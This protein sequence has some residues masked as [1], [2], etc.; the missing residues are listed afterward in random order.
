MWERLLITL[1]NIFA[2]TSLT[3]EDI[4]NIIISLVLAILISFIISQI[5]KYTHY[6]MTYDQ[7]FMVSLVLL[8]PIVAAIML[9]VQGSLV[10]SL[11]LIG[12]L[13]IIRFR[14]PIKDSLDMVFLFWVSAAGLGCGTYNWTI[15]VIFSV[16]LGIVILIMQFTKYGKTSSQYFVL[17]INGKHDYPLEAVEE[18]LKKYT[19]DIRIRSHEVEDNVWEAIFEIRFTDLAGEESKQFIQELQALANVHKISLLAP[20]L[21]LPV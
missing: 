11:G 6:G 9:F 8:G 13:S 17:V 10:V 2:S 15:A 12:S 5:Y 19:S 18:I 4:F 7:S 3:T 21:A 20:Q 16:V 14:T 1:K